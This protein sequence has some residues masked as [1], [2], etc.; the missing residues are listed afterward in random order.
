MLDIKNIKIQIK[1]IIE[2]F[3]SK[4]FIIPVLIFSIFLFFLMFSIMFYYFIGILIHSK[5]EI[6]VPNIVGKSVVEALDI[7]S[8]L[9]LSLKK[10]GEVYNPDYPA[11]TVVVQRPSAGMSVRKGRVV[12]VILSLG[13]EKVFVPNLIGE[14]KRKAEVI[15]RQYSLFL[16]TTTHRYSLKY[17]KNIVMS[18]FPVPETIVEK[19]SSVNIE[20]SLGLPP[21][22][23]VLVPDFI[24]KSID[25]VYNWAAKYDNIN[26][27]VNEEFVNDIPDGLVLRQSIPPDSEINPSEIITFEVTI[28]KQKKAFDG[29]Q[30]VYNFEY[31]LPFIGD[32]LKMVKIVQISDEGEFILY[33]K[34]TSSKQ[35][36]SLYV[37]PRKN[38]KLRIFVDGVLIDEK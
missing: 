21:F 7:V 22:G 34:P 15:L 30:E 4:K 12:N 32:S 24:N 37:P 27:K 8:Q 28:S 20:V 23:V 26:I 19:N 1:N 10:I 16:G 31:E 9:G 29:R 33:N 18:Q 25:N 2:V 6:I 38:S 11:A 17:E 5:K 35:K 3:K 36:I 13:G 14:D